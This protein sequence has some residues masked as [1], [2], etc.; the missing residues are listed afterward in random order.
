M[1]NDNS[2]NLDT[3]VK[4][5]VDTLASP[6]KVESGHHGLTD[7]PVQPLEPQI[8]NGVKVYHTSYIPVRAVLHY[9][10][11]SLISMEL[12]HIEGI[13]IAVFFAITF[14]LFIGMWK[15]AGLR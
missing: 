7:A 14:F 4:H 12:E 10:K 8:I 9:P 11:K 2:E 13:H 3:V 5:P 6:V 15:R 1:L